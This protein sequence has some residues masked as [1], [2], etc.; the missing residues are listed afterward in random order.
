M[1]ELA[2]DASQIAVARRFARSVV[3]D[4]VSASATAD[5]ELVVSELVANVI[6]HSEVS[7]IPLAIVVDATRVSISVTT[8]APVG[9]LGP[10]ETWRVADVREVSGRGLGMVRELADH[11][12]VIDSDAGAVVEVTFATA[13]SDVRP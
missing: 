12:A 4:R 1:I 7:S 8:G 5:V 6:E 13:L 10:V 9:E 11:V 3:R 2:S